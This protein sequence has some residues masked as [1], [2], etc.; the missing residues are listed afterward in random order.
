MENTFHFGVAIAG[1]RDSVFKIGRD[2]VLK[3]S[4]RMAANHLEALRG[5]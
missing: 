5:Y 3:C 2:L 4:V 1:T